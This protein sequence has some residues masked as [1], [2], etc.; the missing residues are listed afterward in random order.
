MISHQRCK[1][2]K[3]RKGMSEHTAECP[4]KPAYGHDWETHSGNG[5]SWDESLVGKLWRTTPGKI[6]VVIL[7]F[8]LLAIL[9]K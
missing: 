3:Q 5:I 1:N 6:V 8:I 2:C 4:A 9:S 7:G